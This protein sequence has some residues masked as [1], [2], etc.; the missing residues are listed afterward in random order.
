MS[1]HA[2]Y[3]AALRW[4]RYAR[5][6]GARFDVEKKA[7]QALHFSLTRR[8]RS[9]AVPSR[10]EGVRQHSGRIAELQPLQ[11][12]RLHVVRVGEGGGSPQLLACT[13]RGEV[14]RVQAKHHAWL[15]PLVERG[16]VRCHV[17]RVTGGAPER[18]SLGVNVA[19]S[20]CTPAPPPTA[21][22]PRGGEERRTPYAVRPLSPIRGYGAQGHAPRLSRRRSWA[23]CPFCGGAGT[24]AYAEPDPATGELCR[25]EE[26]CEGCD[27]AGWPGLLYEPRPP[28]ALHPVPVSSRRS[29]PRL[30]LSDS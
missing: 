4:A 3:H 10:L 2:K 19:F 6:R 21:D 5:R 1:I 7:A 30:T 12:L 15:L 17:L 23:A 18:P 24:V 29:V 16:A 9:F 22:R 11:P 14:G 20:F 26:P 25:G 28:Y 27:G 8:T 13:E